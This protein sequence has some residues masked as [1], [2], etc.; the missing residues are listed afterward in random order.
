MHIVLRVQ[1]ASIPTMTQSR[2]CVLQVFRAHSYT[3]IGGI[4]NRL[5]DAPSGRYAYSAPTVP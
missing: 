2:S 3:D 5:H 1:V 4:E